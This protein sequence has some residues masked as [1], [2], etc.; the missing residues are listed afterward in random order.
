M[1]VIPEQWEGSLTAAHRKFQEVPDGTERNPPNPIYTCAARMKRE[2]KY[3][4]RKKNLKGRIERKKKEEADEEREKKR[5]E[6]EREE[7]KKGK[8]W[9]LRKKNTCETDLILEAGLEGNLGGK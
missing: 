1:E 6:R 2:G 5:R 8:C 7:R 4:N 3:I 9:D